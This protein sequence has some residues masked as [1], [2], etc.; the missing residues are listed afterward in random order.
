MCNYAYYV[1][2]KDTQIIGTF[3]TYLYVIC[4]FIVIFYYKCICVPIN[5]KLVM[6]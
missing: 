3:D 1:P 4:T 2:L 5:N 6:D